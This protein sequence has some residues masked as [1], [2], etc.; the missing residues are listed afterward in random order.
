VGGLD[1]WTGLAGKPRRASEQLAQNCISLTITSTAW[2]CDV[3]NSAG[4]SRTAKAVQ[5]GRVV[6]V[7]WGVGEVLCIHTSSANKD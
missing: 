6:G 3:S 2:N 4:S 1:S 7:G 5:L